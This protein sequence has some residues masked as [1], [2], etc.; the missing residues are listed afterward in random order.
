MIRRTMG[1]FAA[2]A[3]AAMATTAGWA[4]QCGEGQSEAVLVTDNG[5][6]TMC[7]AE[8][9]FESAQGASL[10]L[11]TVA[12]PCADLTPRAQEWK[13]LRDLKECTAVDDGLLLTAMKDKKGGRTPKQEMWTFFTSEAASECSFQV[14]INGVPHR[15]HRLRL[16]S[17]A[18][19]QAC[20]AFARELY[21]D[22]AGSRKQPASCPE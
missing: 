14:A 1:A 17:S 12:C 5:S 11:E 15:S 9:L 21:A 6:I 10:A 13:G 8:D 22:F 19:A 18:E 3:V 2:C 16:A 7:V 4:A 20:E